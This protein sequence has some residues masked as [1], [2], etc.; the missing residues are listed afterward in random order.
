[1]K[2]YNSNEPVETPYMKAKQVWDGR[3]GALANQAS[4]WRITTFCLLGA[5]V[6]LVAALL[7][8]PSRTQLVPYVVEVDGIGQVKQVGMA[9]KPNYVPQEAHIIHSLQSF[10]YNSRAL[11]TDKKVVRENWMRAHRVLAPKVGNQFESYIRDTGLSSKIGQL[12]KTVEVGPVL[13]LGQGSYQIE[14]DEN[15]YDKGG[16]ITLKEHFRGTFAVSHH[17]PKNDKELR[18]NPLGVYI[19]HLD[20][21][22]V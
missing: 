19:H 1:M 18:E 20:W 6:L 7:F 8:L 13:S 21:R 11:S 10:I 16:N 9:N 3:M 15:T 4:M 12:S 5:N 2:N 14:W 22:R 17:Q